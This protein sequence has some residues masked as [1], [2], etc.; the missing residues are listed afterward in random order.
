MEVVHQRG[1]VW[2]QA[3]ALLRVA[4][5][6]EFAAMVRY[7]QLSPRV[8]RLPRRRRILVCLPWRVKGA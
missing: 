4:P 3:V 2:G 5:R 6:W 7:V 8:L 1:W